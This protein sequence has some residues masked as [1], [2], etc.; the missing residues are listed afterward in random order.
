MKQNK[1]FTL[2]ELLV[3]VLIIGILASIALPQYKRAVARTHFAETLTIFS[4]LQK[5]V[6]IYTLE[7]GQAANFLGFWR[8]DLPPYDLDVDFSVADRE[9]L[10][11]ENYSAF[12]TSSQC[13]I[14]LRGN[15][16][17]LYLYRSSSRTSG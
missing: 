10:E 6:D 17:E 9:R 3:V 4:T 16:L 7:N 2:I 14:E 5:A 11:N 15:D 1:G 13:Q 12:C 8:S